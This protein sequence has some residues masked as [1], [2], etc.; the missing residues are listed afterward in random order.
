MWQTWS[1]NSQTASPVAG[2]S[3]R[4]GGLSGPGGWHPT[5]MYLVILLAVEIFAVGVLS[6]TVLR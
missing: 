2:P 1:G 4:G 5:V 6:R 3:G